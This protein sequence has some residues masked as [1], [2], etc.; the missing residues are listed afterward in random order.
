[1]VVKTK[2]MWS[3]ALAAVTVAGCSDGTD[4]AIRAELKSDRVP[5]I[6]GIELQQPRVEIS[7]DDPQSAALIDVTLAV[8]PGAEVKARTYLQ[9]DRARLVMGDFT[10]KEPEDNDDDPAPLERPVVVTYQSQSSR[11][12]R[13]DVLAFFSDPFSDKLKG[14]TTTNQELAS[15]CAEVARNATL[16]VYFDAYYAKNEEDATKVE[17]YVVKT[18]VSF[19]CTQQG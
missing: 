7:L 2:L 12:I 17:P 19:R 6:R 18:L 4:G 14:G 1:M 16:Y 15:F 13:D 9:I 10:N 11:L 8:L 3:V 5:V